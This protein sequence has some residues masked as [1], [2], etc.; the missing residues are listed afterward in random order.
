MVIRTT[1]AVLV[2]LLL[3][4]TGPEVKESM[5]IG[6]IYEGQQL[7]EERI[8]NAEIIARVT[9]RSH[10]VV[11]AKFPGKRQVPPRH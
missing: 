6:R 3:A 2:L 4:C 5:P 10:E 8:V 11:G 9:L 7:L 1:V